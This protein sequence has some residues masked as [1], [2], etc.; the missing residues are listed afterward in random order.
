MLSVS[1]DGSDSDQT[2]DMLPPRSPSRLEFRFGV[3]EDH[4]SDSS[5][6]SEADSAPTEKAVR[7]TKW[8]RARRVFGGTP[9]HILTEHKLSEDADSDISAVD[10]IALPTLRMDARDDSESGSEGSES[11]SEED[12]S[13]MIFSSPMED[14]SHPAAI[15]PRSPEPF[16]TSTMPPE[17]PKQD[18]P[19]VPVKPSAQRLNYPHHGFSR[20]AFMHQK[21]F[22]SARREEWVEWQQR[23][24]NQLRTSKS[25]D[26]AGAY[27]AILDTP[28]MPKSPLP[29]P[30]PP[31]LS[32]RWSVPPSG[33]ERDAQIY[34]PSRFA[35]DVHAPIYPRVG[36]VSALRDPYFANVDRC[37]FQFPLWTIHKTLYVFDMHQR[38]T[39]LPPLR[40][41]GDVND[42]TPCL[43]EEPR[44]G[45]HHSA[46]SDRESD[47]QPS[48]DADRTL[49]AD[50]CDPPTNLPKKGSEINISDFPPQKSPASCP[51]AWDGVRAWELS[52]YARWELFINLIQRDHELQQPSP[53]E[54]MVHFSGETSEQDSCDDDEEDYGTLVSNP[55]FTKTFEEGYRPAIDFFSGGDGDQVKVICV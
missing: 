1:T 4:E 51:G 39:A 34:A 55:I 45:G 13:Q 2:E 9:L 14:A 21:S 25:D 47:S 32:R 44:S 5:T 27:T 28:S 8:E 30:T 22:W 23:S 3:D 17:V 16:R 24:T 7:K 46:G 50:D 33:L 31:P 38:S 48:D 12:L 35:Q 18:L 29:P 11:S 15:E 41:E 19:P 54:P 43:R 36:D 6:D 26:N 53:P 42:P 40:S 37:F 20:S 52:W 49:V 10:L